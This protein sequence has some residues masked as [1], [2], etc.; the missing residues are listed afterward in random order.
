[1]SADSMQRDA[2]DFEPTFIKFSY[3]KNDASTNNHLLKYT[4]G[5]KINSIDA[6]QELEEILF[7]FKRHQVNERL[8]AR[9]PMFQPNDYT[10]PQ[11]GKLCPAVEI[12]DAR[13]DLTEM[14]FKT[15]GECSNTGPLQT[16]RILFEENKVYHFERTKED[17]VHPF[18]TTN[19]AQCLE[20]HKAIFGAAADDMLSF[21]G[22]ERMSAPVVENTLT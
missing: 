13:G 1:M 14:Q 3:E 6:Q 19:P 18:K 8:T 22:V 10:D 4:V 16:S 20:L 12:R 5:W 17:S 15:D 9:M 11:T 21:V 2:A 7:K